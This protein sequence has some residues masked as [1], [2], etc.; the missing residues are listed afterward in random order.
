M[1]ESAVDGRPI[2]AAAGDEARAGRTAVAVKGRT[3][4]LLS[5]FIVD[6]RSGNSALKVISK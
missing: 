3:N 5:D 1:A 2:V 6:F 4:I